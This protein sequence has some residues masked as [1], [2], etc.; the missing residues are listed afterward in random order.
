MQNQHQK[1]GWILGSLIDSLYHLDNSSSTVSQP[2]FFVVVKEH[3]HL[4]HR[5]LG[6]ISV[7]VLNKISAIGSSITE[8]LCCDICH[9]AKQCNLSFLSSTSCASAPFELI[10]C[11]AWGPYRTPTTDGCIYFLTIVDDNSRAIWTILIPIKQHVTKS[12]QDCYAMSQISL[13][14][15][16]NV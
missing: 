10:H 16:S 2:N 9:L 15:L 5:R 4:W 13:L 12:L 14:L 1:K 8:P 3:S 6:H 11:D 7:S